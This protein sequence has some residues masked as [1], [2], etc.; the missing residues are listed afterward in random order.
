MKEK[1]SI[2]LGLTIAAARWRGHDL[3]HEEIAAY[4]GCS[5]Q[6][7]Y[8]VELRALKKLRRR[9]WAEYLERLKG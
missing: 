7:I 3:T 2:D 1:R 4:A 8:L 5:W 9:M 6:Y